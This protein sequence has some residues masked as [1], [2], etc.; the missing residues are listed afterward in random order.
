MLKE[1]ILK[2]L[3]SVS[4]LCA[5]VRDDLICRSEAPEFPITS[6]E[7]L[8]KKTWGLRKG[9]NIIAGRTS[10]GKSC[11]GKQIAWGLAKHKIP[12]M[13]MSLEDD[14]QTIIESIFSNVKE[15]DNYDLLT[16]VF[17]YRQDYQANWM[18]FVK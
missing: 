9:L 17:R 16:G 1:K 18:E 3:H 6:L 14:A 2:E 13:L 7:G 11:L 15:V 8:N 10:Q 12:T 4:S 5:G